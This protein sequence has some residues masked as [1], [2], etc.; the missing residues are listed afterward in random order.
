[1]K[2]R[3]SA[4][5][6]ARGGAPAPAGADVQTPNDGRSPIR[7]AALWVNPDRT[8]G[9]QRI[10]VHRRV[11]YIVGLSR[12]FCRRPIYSASRESAVPALRCR[13]RTMMRELRAC[14]FIALG[15]SACAAEEA[16][17]STEEDDLHAN[18]SDA[19]SG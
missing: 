13:A 1:M 7:V 4:D 10:Q 19:P 5:V 3:S 17:E 15:V 14:A 18:A 8:H 6:K 11:A 2:G 16:N 9:S 12:Q